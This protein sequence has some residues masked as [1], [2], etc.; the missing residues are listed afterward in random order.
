[1]GGLD[2]LESIE[3]ELSI[4]RDESEVS[5][6]NRWAA[7]RPV[8]VNRPTFEL[9]ERSVGWSERT[10]GAFDITAGPLVEAWGF[11]RRSGRK[12]TPEEIADAMRKVGYQRLRLSNEDRS[13]A[14]DRPGMSINLGAIGKG[15]PWIG[16]RDAFANRG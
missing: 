7:D 9:I 14:F 16:W 6:I 1:M 5:R 10:D 3:N 12:P 2:Q 11:T 13:V 4:Y 8:S 15:T